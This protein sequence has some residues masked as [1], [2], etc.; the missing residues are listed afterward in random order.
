MKLKVFG[1]TTSKFVHKFFTFTTYTVYCEL[2]D[3]TVIGLQC[4]SCNIAKLA[5][6]WGPFQQ[7]NSVKNFRLHV[8]KW[9]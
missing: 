2:G 4:V 8:K 7:R 5:V 3:D 1:K 6:F 9:C